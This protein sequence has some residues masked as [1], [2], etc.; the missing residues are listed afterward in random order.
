VNGLPC[1]L[2][3]LVSRRNVPEALEV[4]FTVTESPAVNNG[5]EVPQTNSAA[6]HSETSEPP[7]KVDDAISSDDLMIAL[8]QATGTD[9]VSVVSFVPVSAPS[10]TPPDAPTFQS[11]AARLSSV[12]LPTASD[13]N[14]SASS[15]S[16]AAVGLQGRWDFE[17]DVGI[18][19]VDVSLFQR[20]GLLV[21]SSA[22]SPIARIGQFSR[23]FNATQRQSVSLPLL[24]IFA[25]ETR[26]AWVLTNASAPLS[27]LCHS[28]TD[29]QFGLELRIIN[30]RAQYA[31]RSPTLGLYFSNTTG[32]RVTDGA[33][34]HVA[35]TRTNTTVHVFV[36]GKLDAW[37]SLRSMIQTAQIANFDLARRRGPTPLFFD[38]LL[39]D[40]RIYD[41][42]LAPSEILSAGERCCRSD[43]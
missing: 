41:R 15:F 26:M 19:I 22:L 33:W 5:S 27:L 38:G 28:S 12:S 23:R 29:G 43:S 31:V 30:G 4:V 7:L 14:A 39:D 16:S 9:N 36:D 1:Q 18:A 25:S 20:D 40:L 35:V 13:S 6:Y 24:P 8:A 17:S 42:A 32:T 21:G 10:P 11:S 34:H 3:H 37:G 2:Q